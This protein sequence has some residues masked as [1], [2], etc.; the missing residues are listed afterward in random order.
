MKDT[1]FV[2]FDPLSET[3]DNLIESAIELARPR[4]LPIFLYGVRGAAVLKPEYQQPYNVV[5]VNEMQPSAKEIS[6]IMDDLTDRYRG[7]CIH[8]EVDFTY[9]FE[10]EAVVDKVNKLSDKYKPALIVLEKKSKESLLSEWFGT[11]ET[12]IAQHVDCP[13]LILPDNYR[14]QEIKR[15]T[16]AL[17]STILHI[18]HINF[19]KQLARDFSAEIEIISTVEN[20]AEEEHLEA[21]KKEYAEEK[22]IAVIY[23]KNAEDFTDIQQRAAHPEV[24]IFAF[25]DRERGFFER[26]FNNDNTRHLILST[27]TPVIVF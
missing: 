14:M 19:L 10:G 15:I 8:L 2:A 21:V 13:T 26:L 18:P 25:P 27:E 4:Q 7:K 23:L 22:N 24:S 11:A 1:I 9:G 16:Y 3:K 17:D 12:V 6:K 5:M 20:Q